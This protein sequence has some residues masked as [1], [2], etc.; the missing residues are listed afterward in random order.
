MLESVLG[1]SVP[2]R[3]RPHRA[4]LT[5]LVLGEGTQVSREDTKHCQHQK[6]DKMSQKEKMT[7]L[8][9]ASTTHMESEGADVCSG[10]CTAGLSLFAC[11]LA[12]LWDLLRESSLLNTRGLPAS[13]GRVVVLST[14]H[15]G[16]DQFMN[17][18]LR[19]FK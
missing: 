10:L 16:S 7:S 6:E 17:F 1:F 14:E 12:G 19:D 4:Q 15:V 2:F 18:A 8:S 3:H 11:F 9:Q 5:S 13:T